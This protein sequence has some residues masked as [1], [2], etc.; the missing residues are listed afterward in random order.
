MITDVITV[1][2]TDKTVVISIP[3]DLKSEREF[4][5]HGP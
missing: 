1:M 3:N 4:R 2:I 5:R